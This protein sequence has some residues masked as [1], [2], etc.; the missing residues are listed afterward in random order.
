MNEQ[1]IK[2]HIKHLNEQHTKADHEL[3]TLKTTSTDDLTITRIKK[4]KLALKDQIIKFKKMLT[5]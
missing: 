2:N 1:K 4:T 5:S 3:D